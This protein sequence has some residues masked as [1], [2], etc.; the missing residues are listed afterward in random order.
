MDF[1]LADALLIASSGRAT[2]ISFLLDAICISLC[3]QSRSA[4]RRIGPMAER[5]GFEPPMPFGIHTF[6]AC[7][8]DR[9]DTSPQNHPT[10]GY[11]FTSR[12]RIWRD[13]E[14]PVCVHTRFHERAI[15]LRFP[16]GKRPPPLIT[17]LREIKSNPP[18]KT[19][20]FRPSFKGKV[21]GEPGHRLSFSIY[22]DYA[23]DFLDN[24]IC[25]SRSSC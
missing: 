24:Q 3:H 10:P 15:L 12:S 17:P 9:S 22:P 23:G 7:S 1:S 19:P 16:A 8:F 20:V 4:H 18:R 5:G 25:G 14:A 11:S 21:I 2:S 6:Q 13:T